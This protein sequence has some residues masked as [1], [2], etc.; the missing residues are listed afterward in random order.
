[1]VVTGSKSILSLNTNFKRLSLNHGHPWGPSAYIGY[2]G[3]SIYLS[4]YL[5]IY[6]HIYIYRLYS[7]YIYIY[8]FIYLFMYIYTHIAA[9][10]Y[11][12][13]WSSSRLY[14]ACCVYKPPKHLNPAAKFTLAHNPQNYGIVLILGNAGV[15][16]ST[17]GQGAKILFSQTRPE[18]P[19]TSIGFSRDKPCGSQK[20]VSDYRGPQCQPKLSALLL[21]KNSSRFRLRSL[22]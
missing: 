22:L 4:I 9:S 12:G 14:L 13:N 16:S 15:A 6:L 3:T 2:W 21:T 8:I 18:V 20:S 7:M 11:S 1:M 17:V 19:T 5:P 10:Y